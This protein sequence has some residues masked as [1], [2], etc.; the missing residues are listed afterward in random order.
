VHCNTYPMVSVPDM[1]ANMLSPLNGGWWW[2]IFLVHAALWVAPA[3]IVWAMKEEMDKGK[4]DAEKS[5]TTAY[6]ATCFTAV[7]SLVLFEFCRVLFGDMCD[8]FDLN[9][10]PV[11]QGFIFGFGIFAVANGA[12]AMIGAAQTS[13]DTLVSF[14]IVL[15]L[16]CCGLGMFNTFYTEHVADEAVKYQPRR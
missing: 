14:Q 13:E 12:A 9:L 4:S 15:F 7:I 11:F 6:I 5:I 3:A 1:K 10:K 16:Q 2:L 8:K